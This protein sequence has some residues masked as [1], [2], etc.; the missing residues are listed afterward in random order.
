[1]DAAVDEKKLKELVSE[2]AKQVKTEKDLGELSDQL[3]KMTVEAAL[4]AEMEDHL[5]YEKHAPEGR[6]TG[7]SRNGKS[8][9]KLKGKHGE[10][11]IDTPRDRNGTFEP[12]LLGKYQTRLTAFDDQILCLY[13]K[14]M[15]T[16]QIVDAFQEMY[17]AEV[18]STLVSKVTDAVIDQMTEWQSRP[19]DPLYPIVYLDCIVVKVRQNKQVINKSIY[20]ALGIDLEGHKQLLGLWI[21]ETEGA[22]FWLSVLTELK[23]R[24]VED[25]LIACVDG[26]SGF[27]QAIEAA[28]PETRIQLCIVHMVRNSLKYVSWKDYKAVTRDLRKIYQAP[29]EA[30]ARRALEAF[31]NAWDEKYCQ[32][33]RIWERNWPYLITLFDYPRPIRKAIYTTNAIESLNSV[34]RKATRQRKIFPH[35][36]SALKVT[37][38]AIQAASQKW[39]MPIHHWK[40]AL[41][42]FIIQF[43]DRVTDHL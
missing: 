21:A 18:S 20:I 11:E 8:S 42:Q 12:K 14:G 26:L 33:S 9:K 43:E 16:R 35:D 39:T 31:G 34:I 2:L 17:G 1:M 19:L 10:V 30:E 38:M 27:P 41:N 7:N 4:G 28:Y 13:A 37:F 6:N 40:D 15:T 24:G 22:K 5:G 23:N 36:D 29:T 32:I 3:T 25:I